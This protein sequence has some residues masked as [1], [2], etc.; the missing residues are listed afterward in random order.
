MRADDLV[1]VAERDPEADRPVDERADAEDEDVLAGDVRGVLHPGQAGLEEREAGLHEHD[2]HGRDD[3]PERVR[4]DEQV[5]C[6][7]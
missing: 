6:L 5:C 2:E 7:H 4:G 1:P 3:D